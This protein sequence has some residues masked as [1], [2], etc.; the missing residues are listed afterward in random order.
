MFVE[1]LLEFDADV[2]KSGKK[3]AYKLFFLN[4]HDKESNLSGFFENIEYNSAD[5]LKEAI[6]EVVPRFAS[7]HWYSIEVNY[8]LDG[9]WCTMMYMLRD[10]VEEDNE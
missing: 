2:A 1:R 3:L 7:D 10:E 6:L 9:F 8:K 4:I 5:E